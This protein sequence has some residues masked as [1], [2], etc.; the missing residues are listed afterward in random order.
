MP[1]RI[2]AGPSIPAQ[3]WQLSFVRWLAEA[4]AE[5]AVEE[6]EA[7]TVAVAVKLFSSARVAVKVLA[8]MAR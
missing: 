3:I 4:E 8:A 6:A 1:W 5:Q 7:V 2:N